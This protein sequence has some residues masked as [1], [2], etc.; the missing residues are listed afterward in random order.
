M[1]EV[2]SPRPLRRRGRYYAKSGNTVVFVGSPFSKRFL[3]EL[4]R[5]ELCLG[6]AAVRDGA[7]TRYGF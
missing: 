6:I 5:V 3:A 2:K 7:S 4:D 1:F